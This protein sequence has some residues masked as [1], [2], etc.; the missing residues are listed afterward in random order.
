M[1]DVDKTLKTFEFE[2]CTVE[3]TCNE[4]INVSHMPAGTNHAQS[5]QTVSALDP[6]PDEYIYSPEC[7]DI[8]ILAIE[9]YKDI[10][11]EKKK[12]KEKIGKKKKAQ[13]LNCS[14]FV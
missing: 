1:L 4:L 6:C 10:L 12:K 3:I 11:L 8:D 2:C 5:T 7:F 9:V 13:I 14:L